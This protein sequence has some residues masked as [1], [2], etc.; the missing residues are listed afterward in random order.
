[1]TVE[2]QISQRDLRLRSREIMD[3]V[4]DGQEFI[5]TR[6]GRRIARL[7]TLPHKRAFVPRE[8]FVS[9]GRGLPRIDATAFR[10]DL[11]AA[12]DQVPDDPFDR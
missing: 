6:D 8:E 5:V 11:D 9:L 7:A 12:A 4:E 3:A 10:A 1:V 2:R